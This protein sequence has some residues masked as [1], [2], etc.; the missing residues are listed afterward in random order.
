MVQVGDYR[1]SSG[2]TTVRQTQISCNMFFFKSQNL[3]KAGT[4][5]R[6]ISIAPGKAMNK[7]VEVIQLLGQ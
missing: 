2:F 4:P 6:F 1:V 5:S 3:R 7:M